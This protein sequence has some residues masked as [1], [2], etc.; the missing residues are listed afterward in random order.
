MVN[1][2]KK[3]ENK[4]GENSKDSKDNKLKD[5][6]EEILKKHILEF[7]LSL[8]NHNLKDNKYKSILISTAAVFGVSN[9]Y[10]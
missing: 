4:K 5:K 8:L 9:N 3:K 1:K 7:L 6:K 2:D 10:N